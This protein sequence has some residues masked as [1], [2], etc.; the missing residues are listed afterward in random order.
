MT[1]VRVIPCLDVAGGRVVKGTNFVGL[2]DAGD[3]VELARRYVDQ[4]ADEIAFLDITATAEGR[5]ATIELMHRVAEHVPVPFIVAGG[6]ASV[7]DAKRILDAGANRVSV[8]TAA[9]EHPELLSDLANEIGTESLIV[10]IDA[11]RNE[12]EGGSRFEVVTNGGTKF[13]GLDAIQWAVQA[14]E[15]GAGEV[16]LT[17][18][19]RDGTKDGFDL[20]LTKA[21]A[22][23]VSIPVIASGGVG[24]LQHL[25]DGALVGKA[26]AVLAASIFHFGEHTIEEA[27]TALAQAG[28]QVHITA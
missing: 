10:G 8:A 7:R 11:R 25:V 6:I 3:P 9:V 17:S 19:D 12:I 27:K 2:R 15:L 13:T 14:E 20:E 21:V 4:G 1:F 16:L 23:A 5:G 24:N 26:S 28:V 18:L 22:E